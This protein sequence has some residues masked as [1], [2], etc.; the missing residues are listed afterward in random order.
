MM[1]VQ[2]AR[3]IFEQYK[4]IAIVGLSKDPQKDSYRV[5]EYLKAHGY[6]IIPVNPSA[7]EIL[8]E[9]CYGSLLEMPEDVQK[10]VEV[11]DIFR[12]A[13]DVPPIVDQAIELKKRF[14]TLKVVWMQLGI[15]NEP[16]AA[17]ARDA[18]LEVIMDACMMMQHKRLFRED[19]ELERIRSRKMAELMAQAGTEKPSGG[20]AP[21]EVNDAGFDG[22][23]GRFPLVVVDC[24]AVWC[25]PC[26]MISPVV[27]ELA[28]EY[29][30]RVVFGKLNVDE[31]PETST[32]FGVMA[33]PTLLI[34]KDGEEVDRIVGAVPKEAIRAKL[35]KHL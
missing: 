18:G 5:A 23:V 33:I 9:K 11:V 24:W 32:R 20:D 6:H 17:K 2:S 1:D 12:P 28:K 16:A 22:F 4:T 31:N 8:G 10:T 21:V 34:L 19:T 30:G 15:V 27:E 14:N 13:R 35:A 3:S 25:G 29:A 26:R 7:E